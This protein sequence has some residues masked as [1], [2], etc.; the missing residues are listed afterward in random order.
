MPDLPIR[1][2]RCGEAFPLAIEPAYWQIGQLR[3]ISKATPEMNRQ[4]NFCDVH[5]CGNCYYDLTDLS[6]VTVA[7]LQATEKRKHGN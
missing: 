1:C 4:Y 7:K 6:E 2:I 3:H 5:L